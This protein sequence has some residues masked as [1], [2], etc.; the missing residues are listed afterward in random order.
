MT[1]PKK[2]TKAMYRGKPASTKAPRS[3]RKPVGRKPA[4][5]T[6]RTKPKQAPA[7]TR[8][9]DADFEPFAVTA[10]DIEAFDD[11]QF[12]R[13]MREL[14]RNEVFACNCGTAQFFDNP[15][16]GNEQGQDAET[17]RPTDALPS[18]T[19]IPIGTTVWQYKAEKKP[20]GEAE[21]KAEIEKE[22]PKTI[23]A[24]GGNYRFVAQQPRVNESATDATLRKIAHRKKYATDRVGFHAQATLADRARRYPSLALLPFLN[25]RLE[26]VHSFEWWSKV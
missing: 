23:L 20:P 5:K 22:R 11:Q 7:P 15:G 10:T 19:F 9:H 24:G 12:R 17:T 4:G 8:H 21:L 18:D 25:R 16:D 13:F 6:T 26:Q 14:L 2:K 3:Q 1:R